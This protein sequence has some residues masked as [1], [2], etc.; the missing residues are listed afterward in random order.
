VLTHLPAY[1]RLAWGPMRDPRVG[2]GQKATLLAGVSYMALP[3]D[4]VPGIIPV[5][6]Q[7]DDVAAALLAVRSV[8]RS[9]PPEVAGRH[10]ANANLMLVEVAR[11]VASGGINGVWLLRSGTGL[12]V[13]GVGLAATGIGRGAGAARRLIWRG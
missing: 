12:V 2:R 9:L 7:V 3:F 6:G 10:L 8:P 4:P 5:A 1:T 13:R 11:D